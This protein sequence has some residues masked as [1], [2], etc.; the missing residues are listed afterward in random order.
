MNPRSGRNIRTLRRRIALATS[1]V[2]V[3]TLLQAIAPTVVAADDGN[4]RPAMPKAEKPVEGSTVTK[5]TPRKTT[6]GPR[7]PKSAPKTRW[8]KA[9]SE[10][11]ALPEAPSVDSSRRVKV[12][13][14]PLSLQPPSKT[15]REDNAAGEVKARLLDQRTAEKADLNGLLFTLQAEKSATAG[16]VS[17]TLDYSAFTESFGGSYGSRL[18]L[19][20]LPQCVLTAP[21]KKRC[22]T[23]KPVKTANN[24]EKQTL[25]ATSVQLS[26]SAPTVLAAVAADVGGKG[27]YTATPLSASSTWKT[28]LNTGDFS[29]SYDM[30]VPA[31]PGGLKPQVGLSY[32]SGGIDGRTGGTN[33]Q[34]SWVGDGFDLWPGFIERRY[35]PCADDG[36]VGDG[37]R[38]PGDLC[39]AYDNAYLTFNGKGGE[40]VSAGKDTWRL[41]KDD[42]TKI[43]RIDGSSDNVRGNGARNDEYWRV[44]TPDGTRY[45]FGYHRLPGW[46]DGK[47][48]TGST[49]TAPVFGDDAEE[50]CHASTFADSWCQ[51]AWRWNLDYAVDTHGNAVSYFYNQEKNSYG[52]NQEAANDTRYTRGGYL[53]RIEYGLKSSSMYSSKAL[54]K[55][56]FG[57]S[58]RCLPNASTDCASIGTDAFYWY[59][60]PWDLNCAEATDCDDGKFAPTFWTRKRLTSVTTQVLNSAG[61]YDNIDSWKLAHRW[62]MADTD[63]QLLLD[64]I[65]RIGQSAEPAI[66]V[67]KTTFAY[68]QLENRLDKTGD[69]FAPFIKERLSTV[70]D[71]SGGQ[72]SVD[73]SAPV[74]DW[75]ALPTPETNTT[76]CFPQYIGGSFS[77]DP[78]RQWFNKYVVDSTTAHDRTGRAPDQV[79]AYDYRGDAAWHYDDDDGLTKEKFKTWSQWRGYGH[80]RVKTGGL[81]GDSAMLSQGDTYFLR[82]MDGDRKTTSGGTKSASVTLGADEGD[83]ITDHEA[84]AGFAYKT[85]SYSEPNGKILSKTVNRPWYHQTAKKTRDWGTVTANFTGTAHT[86]TWASLDQGAGS[87]WRITSASTEYDTVAGRPTQVDDY[88]D[89]AIAKDNRCTR[90]TYA[91]NT[92]DNIL[93][94]PSRT[95]T[96]GVG[97]DTTPDRSKDVVSDTRTSYDGLTYDAAPAK[98]DATATAVLKEH[99]GTTAT[100]LESGATYD[101]Y[102]RPLTTTDLT[103]NVTATVGGSPARTARND[104]RVSTLTYSPT[105]GFASS[106]TEVTPPALA[107]DASTAQKTVTTLDGKRGQAA[108]VTDTNGNKTKLAYDALGRSIKVWTADRSTTSNSLPNF[109]FDYQVTEGKPVAV[110]SRTLSAG[111][112]RQVAAYTLYDGFLRQR[113]TQ[114]PGPDSGLLLTDNFYDVR[115]QLSRE[116]ATYYTKDATVGE[117][118]K[119]DNALSVETQIRHAYDGLGRETETKTLAGTG[120]GGTVLGVTKTIYGGDR[121]TVIPPEGGTATTAL[122]D[123]RGQTTELRQHHQPTAEAAYDKTSYTHTKQGALEKLTDPAGNT[124]SYAYDQ[125]GRQITADDPDKGITRS[126]YDDRGQLTTTK[127][128]RNTLLTHIYDGLGRQTELRQDSSTGPLR[129]KWVYDTV[130]D[131]KG[132]LAE[133]TRYDGYNA[134]TYKVTQYDRLYRATRTAVTIPTAETGLAGTYQTGVSY[135]PSGVMAGVTYSGAG[136]LPG[137]SYSYTYDEDTLRPLAMLGDGYSTKTSYSLTGKPLQYELGNTSDGKK[138]WINNAYETGT[139]RLVNIHVNRQDI[140]GVDKD[141]TYRYDQSGNVISAA[142]VSRSGTD[143]QCYTYDYLRR[144]TEAWTEADNSCAAAPTSQGTG[145]LAAYWHSYTY[146]KTGNRLTET[147]HDPTGNTSKDE[148]STY[149]YPPAGQRR[150]HA[151]ASRTTTAGS[152]TSQSS[153]TY[154]EAGNTRTRV[155]GGDTQTLTW[156]PEGHLA[157]VAGTAA[158]P[159]KG[160]AGKCVDVESSQ[161]ADGTP[162]QLYDCNGSDAQQWERT[163]DILKALGKCATGNGTKV[164]LSTCDGGEDQTFIERADDASLYHPATDKCLDVPSSNQENGTD[165][166]L[167]TCNGTEA[168]QWSPSDT[169]R[170]TYDADGNRL[171]ARTPTETTLYLGHTEI[172]VPKGSSTKKATRYVGLGRGHQAVQDNDGSVSF[173]LADHQGTGQLAISADA[174]KLNVRRTLPFGG[175]RGNAPASWPGTK[176]FVGGT[177]DPSTGLTHLGA[178]EY[179][180][181][182]GRF[183]SV[184]PLMDLANPQQLN[185][186]SYADNTPITSSDPSGLMACASPIE[187]G[188]G[189]QYGNNTPSKNSGGKPLNHPSWGCNGCDGNSYNNGWWTTSGWSSAPTGPSLIPGYTMVFPDVHVPADWDRAQ[190]FKSELNQVLQTYDLPD[191]PDSGMEGI[192][193]N[194]TDPAD[195]EEL[196]NGQHMLEIAKFHACGRIGNNCPKQLS[197]FGAAVAAGGGIALVAGGVGTGGIGRGGGKMSPSC[198]SFV[199]GTEVLLADGTKKP[200]EELKIGDEVLATDPKTGKTTAKKVT[201]EIKGEGLKNLVKIT[202]RP[203]GKKSGKTVSVTATDGHPFWVPEL[204]EW[205]DATDLQSGQWLRTSSAKRVQVAVVTRW[206]QQAAVHNLTVADLHTYYV[207]A[208]KTPVLV[209]NS[210]GEWCTREERIEDASDIGNGHAGSKHAGDFPGHSPQEIGD[211]ARDA[212]ENPARTKPLGGGRRA[213]QG[214]DGSTIVIHDPMH[215]DGGTVFRRDPGTIDDYWDGLN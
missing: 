10:I 12:G 7:T 151:L 68:T 100:Y 186:Y 149:T 203:D 106:V 169:T 114:S 199:P 30:P 25:T 190:D 134:Y 128:A 39:W 13:G 152:V 208:G 113:Q 117:L 34:S 35:K 52:R 198:N 69:G 17:A 183:I 212:M 64:S 211:V 179:D 160:L 55:V 32:S 27:D 84:A 60:T 192:A 73:Y 79:T 146:D 127:D 37:G 197:S 141:T 66:T 77:D 62:G 166:Q 5:S 1:A 111:G 139:Q 21:Q 143:N 98:G 181:D 42:G 174:Q 115:G 119:P 201:A 129:A 150:P 103:A 207:L 155:L 194:I 137:G 214:K 94:L 22:Q 88:R 26:E 193:S 51:Q 67:P 78:E 138:T 101:G 170:Y 54:A 162:I 104:G 86:K 175:I 16:R 58:E 205:I 109:Q 122:V 92:G 142:D 36:V 140:A 177:N 83:P 126:T 53:D 187:C 176:S 90:T 29:W 202:L 131:G 173:T 123:A 45:Y 145:G 23:S 96:V 118:F 75:N 40:L 200:I 108:E 185:G 9:A 87:A 112:G 6:K 44:T 28:N 110:T 65:Q 132:Q 102:G 171:I 89:N 95:E 209:H 85:V 33:N 76:R 15:K 70:D 71:E 4:G 153:Y 196:A 93:T 157:K 46:S 120:D 213:Y 74:C 195:G 182:L 164:Q 144:L 57:N 124:W 180:P 121:T 130:S 18:T 43:A 3:G 61:G 56:T 154:D 72:I 63:Y 165:L 48:T 99:N 31:V 49:W 172:T 163:G 59:D 167:Y 81:G 133:A 158:V 189:A 178:R 204:Q 188:G 147:Q 19:V 41:K 156:D 135:K 8:P 191:R 116:F 148:K 38:K 91:T 97:C 161:T 47:E 14:L 215:P 82:G 107:Q 210:G 2:M 125:L 159:I 50:P 136:A 105:T 24:T 206:K 184:D 80:V 20:E 11:V 168:Q